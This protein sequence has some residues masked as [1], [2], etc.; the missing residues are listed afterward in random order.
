MARW[1]C[2]LM[3]SVLSQMASAQFSH[4]FSNLFPELPNPIL[5]DHCRDGI[6][7]EITKLT[8]DLSGVAKNGDYDQAKKSLWSL[9]LEVKGDPEV[10]GNKPYRMALTNLFARVLSK[11]GRLSDAE[12]KTMLEQFDQLTRGEFTVCHTDLPSQIVVAMDKAAAQLNCDRTSELLKIYTK[13]YTAFQVERV[14]KQSPFRFGQALSKAQKAGCASEN[15]E[16]RSDG[17]GSAAFQQG[18]AIMNFAYLHLVLNHIPISGIPVAL[19]FLVFGLRTNN[20]GMERLALLVLAVLA[21][22]TAPV[23]L[24]GESAEEIMENQ[25]GISELIVESHEDVAKV[26]LILTFLTGA[27]AAASWF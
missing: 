4:P 6:C 17:P 16:L 3:F 2:G 26:S 18:E 9:F 19:V 22:V 27:L 21:I 1:I 5:P 15:R 10:R 20:R 13:N 14:L 24:T 7:S 8:T 11:P 23:F 12:W 25:P